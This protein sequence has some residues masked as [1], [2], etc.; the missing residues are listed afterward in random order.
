MITPQKKFMNRHGL[1]AGAPMAYGVMATVLFILIWL[2][3]GSATHASFPNL[4]NGKTFSVS[5]AN[6]TEP[7]KAWFCLTSIFVTAALP[8]TAFAKWLIRKDGRS[9]YGGFLIL[10]VFLW[11]YVLLIWT[12]PVSWLAH[13]VAK[14]GS[15]PKRILGLAY[16]VTGYAI[17]LGVMIWLAHPFTHKSSN[18]SA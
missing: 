6:P 13:Y 14:T 18:Q 11:L 2:I 16:G 8:S 12:V 3:N 10:S 9:A 4:I 17:V 7:I 15:T 5:F 1:T